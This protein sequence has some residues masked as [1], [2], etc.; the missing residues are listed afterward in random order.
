M[1]KIMLN[2]K[3]YGVG[4]IEKAKDISYDN[5]SSGMSATNVQGALDEVKA[6]L[7]SFQFRKVNYAYSIAA[8]GNTHANLYSI[9]NNDMPSGYRFLAFAGFNTA[10][11]NVF[12]SNCRYVN[13]DYSLELRNVS[14]S[15]VSQTSD[16]FYLCAK[17]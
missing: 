7:S 15:A 3:Q 8:N 4:G 10:S 5:T 9:I 12:M 17:V 14:T 16:I 13:S 11:V 6:G 2:G 1:G